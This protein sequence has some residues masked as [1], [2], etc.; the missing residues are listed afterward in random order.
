ME[1]HI[2]PVMT[3]FLARETVVVPDYP[4]LQVFES[5]VDRF[6]SM[7]GQSGL[8]LITGVARHEPRNLRFRG[9]YDA[10][11]Q[12]GEFTFSAMTGNEF[13]LPQNRSDG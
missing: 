11:A 1:R 2:R 8:F 12:T 5:F 10:T 3:F 13:R 4:P 6:E 7:P 9:T